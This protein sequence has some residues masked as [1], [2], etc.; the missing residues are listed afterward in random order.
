[1]EIISTWYG[2]HLTPFLLLTHNPPLLLFACS[3]SFLCSSSYSTSLYC[4]SS[5]SPT[6]LLYVFTTPCS[7]TTYFSSSHSHQFSTISHLH[8]HNFS[9]SPPL[10]LHCFPFPSLSYSSSSFSTASLISNFSFSSPYSLP[11]I[12]TVSLL[13]PFYLASFFTLFSTISLLYPYSYFSFPYFKLLTSSAASV[14][15]S[16]KIP[17][18]A[19]RVRFPGGAFSF[20]IFLFPHFPYPALLFL[21]SILI[22]LILSFYF[23]LPSLS[24]SF[25]TFYHYFSSPAS[26]LFLLCIFS[27][28]FFYIP[29]TFPSSSIFL[30]PLF[31]TLFSLL[32]TLTKS[33]KVK[34][35][36]ILIVCKC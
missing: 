20:S 4:F 23:S 16:C 6:I 35:C 24:S 31:Y 33:A 21:F 18:L 5:S 3:S 10:I 13:H 29:S 32:P 15:V 28:C 7:P 2:T 12:F 14:V 11:H 36:Y 34:P 27:H 8:S 26:L 25:F 30:H 9:F 1:M 19:T 22:L 17:I